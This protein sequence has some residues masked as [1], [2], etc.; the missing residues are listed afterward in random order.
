MH[1]YSPQRTHQDIAQLWDLDD[2]A[3]R[4]L[5]VSKVCMGPAYVTHTCSAVLHE[6][7]CV[8]NFTGRDTLH[9][10]KT[11][12]GIIVKTGDRFEG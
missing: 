12:E 9:R 4:H 11:R 8:A 6:E 7:P 5:T 3:C 10:D 1:L 2:T